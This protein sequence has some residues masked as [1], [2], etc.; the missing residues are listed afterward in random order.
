MAR[1][2]SAGDIA[3]AMLGGSRERKPAAKATRPTKPTPDAPSITSL[4]ERAA[5]GEEPLEQLLA[6]WQ[7]VPATELAEAIAGLPRDDLAVVVTGTAVEGVARLTRVERAR[8]PRI[9][10][11]LASW[12]ADPPWHATGAKPFYKAALARLVEIADPR[13]A[14]ALARAATAVAKIIKG[15]SMRGWLAAEIEK[16][17]IALAAIDAPV[18]SARDRGLVAKA[19]A[20]VPIAPRTT[21]KP[22]RKTQAASDLLAAI[23]ADPA[24]D[25]AHQVYADILVEQ[26]DP[27][28]EFIS[29]QLAR[30][31]RAPSEQERKRETALLAK[32][33]REWLGEL[34]AVVGSIARHE[35]RVGPMVDP[36]DLRFE[37]GFL[38]GCR[39]FGSKRKLASVVGQPTLATVEDLLTITDGLAILRDTQLPALR[40][41]GVPPHTSRAVVTLPFAR[42]LVVL[43]LTG[44]IE[45]ADPEDVSCWRDK[46]AL[47]E[48]AL[49]IPGETLDPGANALRA[50]LALP[51]LQRIEL[52]LYSG[53]G[54]FHRAAKSWAFDADRKPTPTLQRAIDAL[55]R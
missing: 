9:A 42:Q 27:R 48:L 39:L 25:G 37:R 33:V 17:R 43:D 26:G 16:T 38:A 45:L 15:P 50:A 40:Q 19:A 54:T 20:R 22:S 55:L 53:S 51:Q 52:S 6:A 36:Y 2:R 46:P 11:T 3:M 10:A 13:S 47:R 31:G 49:A 24:D 1:K 41:L 44:E 18:L 30:A 23:H 14:K 21:P 4:L 32:H 29:L 7:L 28:G 35:L 12:L 34:T 5:A 8:D